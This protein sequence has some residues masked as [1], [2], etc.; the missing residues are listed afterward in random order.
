LQNLY[1]NT[2]NLE[3]KAVAALING[4]KT[5]IYNCSFLGLQV[6]YLTSMD[7]IILEDYIFCYGQSIY[8]VCILFLLSVITFIF[9][10]DCWWIEWIC[11][12]VSLW[13]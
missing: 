8:E 13:I 11:P 5:S 2:A 12:Y 1:Q 6:L 10:L 4:E 9:L 7:S 3:K